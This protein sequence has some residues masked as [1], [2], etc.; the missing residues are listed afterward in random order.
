MNND[1]IKCTFDCKSFLKRNSMSVKEFSEKIGCSENSILSWINGRSKPQYD[2]LI[3]L[4]Y[5]GASIDELFG[6]DCAMV[7]A[8]NTVRAC[9]PNVKLKNK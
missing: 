9:K 6:R 1:K 2:T 3:K 5:S 7:L 8:S 4:V